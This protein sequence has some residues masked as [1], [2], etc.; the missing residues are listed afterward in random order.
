VP[1]EP[2]TSVSVTVFPEQ[3][4]LNGAL[5]DTPVGAV[6]GVFTCTL[7]VQPEEPQELVAVQVTVVLPAVNTDPDEGVH[8]TA[9]DGEPVATGSI[10]VATGEH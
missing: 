5:V 4:L 8:T 7:N 10:Q 1:G 6:D 2:P 3:I 9:G